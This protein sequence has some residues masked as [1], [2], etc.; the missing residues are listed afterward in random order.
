MFQCCFSCER[1]PA[2][3][4][5]FKTW[6]NATSSWHSQFPALPCLQ[7]TTS[8]FAGHQTGT[9]SPWGTRTTSS[10]SS[11]PGPGNPL[12]MNSSNSR[13][14][15]Y[16]RWNFLCFLKSVANIFMNFSVHTIPS[17]V[18]ELTWNN[19]GDLFFL[20]SGQGSIHILSYPDLKLQHVIQVW[21][22]INH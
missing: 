4:D 3:K 17:Q 1:R 14:F 7:A 12:P 15:K 8:T 16:W 18:N 21:Q 2:V 20:T 19:E 22:T 13:W 10:P 11:T 5:V 9:T 6:A